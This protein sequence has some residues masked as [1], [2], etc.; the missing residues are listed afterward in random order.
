MIALCTQYY[1]YNLPKRFLWS[2]KLTKD[3]EK[4]RPVH[5]SFP[6]HI[7]YFCVAHGSWVRWS[8]QTEHHTAFCSKYHFLVALSVCVCVSWSCLLSTVYLTRS[9]PITQTMPIR[10]FLLG[11]WIQWHQS[12]SYHL[13]SQ[14]KLGFCE[15][16]WTKEKETYFIEHVYCA[17]CVPSSILSKC[18]VNEGVKDHNSL[19]KMR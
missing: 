7:S 15:S 1:G 14:M 11:I 5:F 8:A 18:E 13:I 16:L 12:G 19:E 6:L 4:E 3:R 9:G 2:M 17:C 10:F